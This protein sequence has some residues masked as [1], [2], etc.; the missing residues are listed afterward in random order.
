M[1]NISLEILEALKKRP[2][3]KSFS[4]KLKTEHWNENA[5]LTCPI[6]G[7][8]ILRF[9][10]FPPAL[11]EGPYLCASGDHRWYLT[12]HSNRMTLEPAICFE[13]TVKL[14][15]YPESIFITEA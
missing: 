6:C 5:E 12:A 8:A 1:K 15:E 7:T 13:V 3:F 11:P 14:T 10:S 4:I 9:G 2:L